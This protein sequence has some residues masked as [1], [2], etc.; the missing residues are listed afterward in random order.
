MREDPRTKPPQVSPDFPDS[1]HRVT[2]KGIYVRD[3]KILLTHDYVDPED[4]VWELPGGGLDFGESIP[5]ALRREVK[6]EMGLTVTKMY[7]SPIY[8]WPSRRENWRGLDWY[9]SLVLGYRIEI[10]TLETLVP[11]DECREIKFFSKEEL[12]RAT[13]LNEQIKELA[14]IFDP[15]DFG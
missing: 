6:E 11:S 2:V 14:K 13:D 10:E 15:K 1:F 5:D 3:G 4:P 8:V 12:M 9:Y 7:E